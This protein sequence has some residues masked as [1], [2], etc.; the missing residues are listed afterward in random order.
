[1]LCLSKKSEVFYVF[2]H[3]VLDILHEAYN[4]FKFIRVEE[5]M[6]VSRPTWPPTAPQPEVAGNRSCNEGHR[7]E[8]KRDTCLKPPCFLTQKTIHISCIREQIC[9]LL[10]MKSGLFYKL[11]VYA[12]IADLRKIQETLTCEK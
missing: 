11:H 6:G 10:L 4:L 9:T 5:A 7:R 1:M 12:R 2:T 3:H 8:F